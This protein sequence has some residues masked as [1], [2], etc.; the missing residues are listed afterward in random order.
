[1]S[2]TSCIKG[3]FSQYA[4]SDPGVGAALRRPAGSVIYHCPAEPS[5]PRPSPLGAGRRR[6]GAG[7]RYVS[8]EFCTTTR[9]SG[10]HRGRALRG[11][12]AG[13]YVVSVSVRA[14][15]D[16]GPG[17]ANMEAVVCHRQRSVVSAPGRAQW[18]GYGPRPIWPGWIGT[19]G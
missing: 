11:Q 4:T 15:M 14:C 2:R 10:A 9:L 13:R 1:L 8:V 12:A 3:S 16:Q 6:P 19:G 18:S 17:R 7:G 5:S